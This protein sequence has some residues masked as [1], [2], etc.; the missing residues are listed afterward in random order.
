MVGGEHREKDMKKDAGI[1]RAMTA[2]AAMARS[3]RQGMK[4]Y[5]A[6]TVSQTL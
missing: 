5:A 2:A 3:S 1:T 6:L 4:G